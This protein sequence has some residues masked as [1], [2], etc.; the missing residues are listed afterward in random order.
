ML[1]A[2]GVAIGLGASF[3]LTSLL[4]SMLNDVKPTDL[5]VFAGNAV[6]VMLVAMAACYLPARWAGRV[7]PAVVLR[8]D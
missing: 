5:S 6:L 1:A 3:F 2:A 8:M 7:D 4:E